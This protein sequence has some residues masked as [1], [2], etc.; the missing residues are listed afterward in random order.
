MDQFPEVKCSICSVRTRSFRLLFLQLT[1]ETTRVPTASSC[2]SRFGTFSQSKRAADGKERT[3][4]VTEYGIYGGH[5]N[6]FLLPPC[7]QPACKGRSAL[8]L[9]ENSTLRI[10]ERFIT[11]SSRGEGAVVVVV[12][13]G[14]ERGGGH[15][16]C[17]LC[18]SRFGSGQHE[19]R[20]WIG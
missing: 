16:F 10:E 8:F 5:Y 4:S 9:S 20:Y 13:V 11:L 14:E 17:L 7:V 1:P 18:W 3:T 12:V 6:T 19:L 2:Q 15:P